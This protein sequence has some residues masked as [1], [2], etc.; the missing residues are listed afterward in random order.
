MSQL[1]LLNDIMEVLNS[2]KPYI[3]HP[4]EEKFVEA[5]IKGLKKD[6]F[7]FIGN[8]DY[9]DTV[10]GIF[11]SEIKLNKSLHSHIVEGK[12]GCNFPIIICFV[13]SNNK[14]YE[15][16]IKNGTFILNETKKSM[17][18]ILFDAKLK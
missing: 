10:I 4:T 2:N 17:E 18:E 14:E 3:V 15:I 13:I 1:N 9:N 5:V 7:L 6:Y 12:T 8:D 11:D 16:L